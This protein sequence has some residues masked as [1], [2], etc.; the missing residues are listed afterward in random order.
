MLA[1]V[2]LSI[3]S[4]LAVP[5]TEPTVD[6]LRL[7]ASHPAATGAKQ[8]QKPHDSATGPAPQHL[9]EHERLVV[10]PPEQQKADHKPQKRFRFAADGDTFHREPRE[11][12]PDTRRKMNQA[13]IYRWSWNGWM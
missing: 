5:P 3:G 6:K 9:A 11:A 12:K 13:D 2:A 4:A 1:I 10:V 8:A 7:G